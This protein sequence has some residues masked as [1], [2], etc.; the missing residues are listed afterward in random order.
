M[1]GAAGARLK[2][3]WW[4]WDDRTKASETRWAWRVACGTTPMAQHDCQSP[5]ASYTAEAQ[6]DCQ[7]H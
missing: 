4:R 5:P 6:P 2:A 3:G 7:A 1:S